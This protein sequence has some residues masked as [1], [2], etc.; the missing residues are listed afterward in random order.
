MPAYSINRLPWCGNCGAALPES[1]LT[2]I[3]RRLYSIRYP[4]AIIAGTALLLIWQPAIPPINSSKVTRATTAGRSPSSKDGCSGRTQPYE[5]LYARY[6]SDPGVTTL[7]LKTA[8]GSNYFV[9][10]NDATSG[11]PVLALYLYGGSTFGTQIPRGAFTLKY[12]TGETWC[13]ESE[14]FGS[15]TVTRKV[16]RVI[17]FDDEHEYTIELIAQRNGNLATKEISRDSFKADY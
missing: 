5:G 14:L 4:I 1:P 8:R 6:I 2:T 15:S 3:A 11:R 17:R 16:D 13:D 7:T 10:I 12:A 9:K